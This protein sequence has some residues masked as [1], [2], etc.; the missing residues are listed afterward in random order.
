MNNCFAPDMLQEPVSLILK[1]NVSNTVQDVSTENVNKKS[2]FL[3]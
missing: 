1:C 3:T 2:F